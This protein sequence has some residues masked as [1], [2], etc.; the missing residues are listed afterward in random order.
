MQGLV[1]TDVL[2]VSHLCQPTC[3][4]LRNICKKVGRKNAR[5]RE[6]RRELQYS[7]GY[8]MTGTLKLLVLVMISTRFVQDQVNKK[9]QY[10]LGNVY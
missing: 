9:I 2:R 7:L 1:T 4:R 8:G 3:T 5:V 6:W 10:V